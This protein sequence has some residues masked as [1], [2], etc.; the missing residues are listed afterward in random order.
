MSSETGRRATRLPVVCELPEV[1]QRPR[2]EEVAREVFSRC[3]N[4]RELEDGYEFVFAGDEQLVEGL[5]RFIASERECCRFFT[6]GLLFEPELGPV[7]LRMRGP[8]GTKEF[9]TNH[10]DEEFASKHSINRS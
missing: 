7:L 9:L 10:F 5:M 1:G 6:F 2:R 3:E 8:D 4:V